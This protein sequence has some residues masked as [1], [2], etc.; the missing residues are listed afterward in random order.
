MKAVIWDRYG[1]PEVLRLGEMPKPE[2]KSDEVL[3]KV[4]AATVTLGDCELRAMKLAPWATPLVRLA[5]GVFRPR[6][7]VPGGEAAGEVVA[8]GADVTRFTVGD[9]VFGV[10][11]FS[12]GS[13]AQFKTAKE[14]SGMTIIPDRLDYA[15]VAGI[16]TGGF[17]GLHFVRRA[18]LNAGEQVLINGAGGSIGTF[19]LQVAKQSGAEVTAVDRGDKLEM[20]SGLGAE[21]VIDYQAGDV[22]A[23][24]KTYDVIIDVVGVFGFDEALGA[25]NPG[26]RYVMGNPQFIQMLRAAWHN[27]RGGDKKVLFDLAGEPVEDLD[28]LA[29]QIASGELKMIVDRH[30]PMDEI[31]AAHRYVEAGNKKGIVIIDIPQGDA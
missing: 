3:I 29:G 16:P 7:P 11:G 2:P 17:N 22:L 24:G 14:K 21:H 13:Y 9:R 4:H 20:L 28:L 1:P 19:A 12:L 8:V 26:G 25:L 23:S 30:F 10:T 18:G 6:K 15:D 27:R 5:F 31:V